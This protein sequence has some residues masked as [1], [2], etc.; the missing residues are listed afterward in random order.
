MNLAY[1]TIFGKPLIF[2]LGI[3][4]ISSVFITAIIGYLHYT[5]RRR[6]PFKWHIRFAVLSLILAALHGLMG[7]LS[8]I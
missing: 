2:Y 1:Y 5:E 8:S 6:I 3:F 7:I 4:T